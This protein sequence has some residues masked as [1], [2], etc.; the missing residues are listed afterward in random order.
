M[1]ETRPQ[2]MSYLPRDLPP[3]LIADDSQE[4]QRLLIALLA[5]AGVSNPVFTFSDGQ[6]L[7]GFLRGVCE[8]DVRPALRPCLLFLDLDMP[9]V[10]GFEVA[11]A[12]RSA[13][14]LRS[15]TIVVFPGLIPPDDN[16]RA[17][18]SDAYRTIPK[19]PRAEVFSELVHTASVN[20]TLSNS[21]PPFAR[22]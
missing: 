9:R 10:S 15:L 16:A 13:P 5:K 19:F 21:N 22:N 8:P 20:F 18:R 3:V 14:A 12:I 7:M 11:E 17:T 6:E 2:L 1:G 4:D